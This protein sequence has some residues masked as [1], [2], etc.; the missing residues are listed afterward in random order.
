MEILDLL[1]CHDQTISEKL[2]HAPRNALY[3]SPDIQNSLLELMDEMVCGKISTKIDKAGYFTLMAD[4]SKDCSKTEQLAIIFHYANVDNGDVIHERFLTFV[5]AD[6]L[7]AES[8]TGYIKNI[9]DNY[10]FDHKK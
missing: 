7:N 3:V 5:Q 4:E 9:I 2:R 1:A 6:K 10:K 8:L